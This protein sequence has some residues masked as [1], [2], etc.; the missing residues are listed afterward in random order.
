MTYV[1]SWNAATNTPCI[2]TGSASSTN[3]GQYYIVSVAG[4]TNVDGNSTWNVGDQI[5]SNGSTWQRIPNSYDVT[6]VNGQTGAVS[7]TA[8][9]LNLATV[10]TSGSY[11]DLTNTPPNPA[12]A[13]ISCNI[14]GNPI[15]TQDVSYMF[16]RSCNMP[17][18]FLSSPVFATLA[19]GT[20]ATVGIFKY[21]VSNPSTGTQIGSVV[22][23][24]SGQSTF[25]STA[26]VTWNIGDRM[27]YRFTTTN[28]AVMSI[29]LAGT[30]TS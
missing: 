13:S 12:Q 27:V 6:S 7:I 3:K 9:T 19:S 11:A 4:T 25:S 2:T 26:A 5:V 21:P 16:S 20:S 23:N 1:G 29:T 10:A 28:I 30:W 17:M 8:A 24:T 15:I 18:N 14:Q 22:I